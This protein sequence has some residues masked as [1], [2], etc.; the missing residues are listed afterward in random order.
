VFI[1]Y[2]LGFTLMETCLGGLYFHAY[3]QRQPLALDALEQIH[4]RYSLNRSLAG[5][6]IGL[7]ATVIALAA[8]PQYAPMSCWSYALLMWIN[9]WLR[10]RRDQQA[11][12]L[13][14]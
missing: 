7:L 2:G 11:H 6:A 9:P 1:A 4:T 13:T 8:P 12:G 5:I 3:R 14:G 10:R